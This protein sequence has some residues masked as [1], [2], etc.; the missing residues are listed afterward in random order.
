MAWEVLTSEA[1]F[2]DIK[3]AKEWYEEQ[4]NGLSLDYELCLDGGYE[5]IL[6]NPKAFQIKYN[7]VRVCYIARFPFGIHYIIEKDL[8]LVLGVFHTK[9]NPIKWSKR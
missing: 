7:K 2:E 4:R 8:I 5:D 9:T 6:D 1:A 3:R